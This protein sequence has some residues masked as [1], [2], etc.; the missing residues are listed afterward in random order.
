MNGVIRWKY[1]GKGKTDRPEPETV[2]QQ[3]QALEG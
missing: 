3:L 2:L 1:I